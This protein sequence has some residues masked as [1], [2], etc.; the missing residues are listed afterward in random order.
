MSFILDALRKSDAERQ[1]QAVPGLVDAGYRPPAPRRATWIPI[2]VVVLAANLAL[3][4]G[5]WWRGR[6]GNEAAPVPAQVAGGAAA[7]GGVMVRR[8][9]RPGNTLAEVA[10]I[11]P[12]NDSA[13]GRA[14]LE[15]APGEDAY[16]E[17]FEPPLEAG[18]GLPA[19]AGS[20][21]AGD[22]ASESR[23]VRAELPTA[24]ELAAS[25]AMALPALHLDI[26]VYSATPAERFAFIN[27]KK[28][29]EGTAL[30]EGPT[31]E[32]ITSEGVVLSHDG[33]R[34]LLTRE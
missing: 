7:S 14:A 11:A 9:E 17:V 5:F 29:T 21:V 31:V 16:T 27:M 3:M 12:A 33:Q 25:G 32:E 28:Y 30:A 24:S 8:A 26:H 22:P 19:V 34:F 4:A 13:A 15:E 6:A 20:A 18:D 10:G 23:I 2:L 1:R